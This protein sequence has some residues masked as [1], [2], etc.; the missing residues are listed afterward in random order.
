MSQVKFFESIRCVNY[1]DQKNAILGL[2][3]ILSLLL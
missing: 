1:R 3:P 2:V